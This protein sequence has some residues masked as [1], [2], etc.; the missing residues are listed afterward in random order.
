[1]H[2]ESVFT[3]RTALSILPFT[4]SE[5]LKD[6][7]EKLKSNPDYNLV[8]ICIKAEELS[9]VSLNKTQEVYINVFLFIFMCI[10]IY[11]YIYK[12]I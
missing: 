6:K 4:M 10:Q 2:E 8:E 9:V 7:L 12:H 3:K 5:E 11:L 1:M